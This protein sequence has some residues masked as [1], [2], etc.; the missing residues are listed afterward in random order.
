M[1]LAV[2]NDAIDRMKLSDYQHKLLYERRP[3]IEAEMRKLVGHGFEWR[4]ENGTLPF[5]LDENP[6][7]EFCDWFKAHDE[8]GYESYLM[9]YYVPDDPALKSKD[10]IAREVIRVMTM[11]QPL[12]DAMVWRP[13]KR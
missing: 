6:I 2:K 8:E 7:E 13:L 1:F 5:R 11:L 3:L 10:S 12:Y 4:I 9:K